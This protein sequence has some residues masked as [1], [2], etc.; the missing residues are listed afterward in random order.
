MIIGRCGHEPV[1]NALYEIS[2]RA[3]TTY[4]Y[5]DPSNCIFIRLYAIFVV[6]DRWKTL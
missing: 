1:I 4:M 6:N 5:T 3:V 2:S